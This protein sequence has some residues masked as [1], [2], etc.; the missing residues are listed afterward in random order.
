MRCKKSLQW[1]ACGSLTAW[2]S[3][4]GVCVIQGAPPFSQNPSSSVEDVSMSTSD[5]PYGSKI[6]VRLYDS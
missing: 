4:E 1:K 2:D 5:L 6:S 3:V